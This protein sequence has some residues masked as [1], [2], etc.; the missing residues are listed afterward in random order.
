MDTRNGLWPS[1]PERDDLKRALLATLGVLDT[2][3]EV[4]F[5]GLT[6]A[7]ALATGCPAAALSF[8]DGERR[9][10]KS[11]Y[12]L[13]AEPV[14]IP[15]G[16]D[17]LYDR[18]I[19]WHAY[20]GRQG[21]G[22]PWL[23]IASEPV[24][25]E[26]ELVG[27][28]CVGDVQDRESLDAER[29]AALRGLADVA[30]SLLASRRPGLQI[31]EQAMRRRQG[32]LT[33]ASHEMRTPLNAVLGFSQL[34]QLEPA[35]EG[36]RALQWVQQIEQ[37]SRHLL[38]LVEEMLELARLSSGRQRLAPEPVSL[39]PVIHGCLA[40]LEPTAQARSV[41][42][43]APPSPAMSEAASAR[44]VADPRALRQ[45][46]I[47][48]LANAIA[49]SPQGGTVRVWVEPLPHPE[50]WRVSVVDEGPGISPADL[51]QLFQ[52]FGRVGPDEGRPAG[53]GLGLAISRQLA[54]ALHGRLAVA[55][56]PGRGSTFTLELPA[57]PLRP[58]LDP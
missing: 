31:D 5:D 51:A 17:E 19:D 14:P 34:L 11:Q 26:R 43:R 1:R 13:A 37:A 23:Y 44:V 56:E 41:G 4:A 15:L 30:E 32:L 3:P 54:E 22:G 10:F 47:N 25:S 8:S 12:G 42:L 18:S 58:S 16:T 29:R 45:I 7:A 36:S 39:L 28:L 48:L 27:W 6:R 9:W 50:R 33:R 24:R 49:H 52:P 20:V 38:S 46:L 53:T 40:M 57:A 21:P 55:S 35:L 2:G